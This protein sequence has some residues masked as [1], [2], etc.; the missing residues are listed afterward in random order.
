MFPLIL[1]PPA[2]RHSALR[3][4]VGPD[5]KPA[6]AV[7]CCANGFQ[8][9]VGYIS[10]EAEIGGSVGLPSR[11][12]RTSGRLS[13]RVPG[14]KKQTEP[15]YSTLCRPHASPPQREAGNSPEASNSGLRETRCITTC[16][17]PKPLMPQQLQL[18][19]LLTHPLPA[20]CMRRTVQP[21]EGSQPVPAA[22]SISGPAL[23]EIRRGALSACST[24]SVRTDAEN[25]RRACSRPTGSPSDSVPTERPR[26]L[27]TFVLDAWPTFNSHGQIIN[28]NR[29][30]GDPDRRQFCFH[31]PGERQLASTS[32]EH[33]NTSRLLAVVSLASTRCDAFGSFFLPSIT[34]NIA[35]M[36]LTRIFL[37]LCRT[38]FG[39]H[40]ALLP[41][42]MR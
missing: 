15:K 21:A 19:L 11:I 24:T 16:P 22:R 17:A 23:H 4:V 8:V 13:L 32:L 20:S 3:G 25:S 6:A 40:D 30:T 1:I 35:Y 10:W 2:A 18:V 39:T 31:L 34:D 27:E 42:Q 33:P 9:E 14:R 28:P 7:I 12:F 38:I 29:S 41:M 26:R 36:H 37:L 5:D